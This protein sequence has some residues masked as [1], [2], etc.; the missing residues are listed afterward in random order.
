M[1][2]RR[3]TIKRGDTETWT[4]TTGHAGPDPPFQGATAVV[5]FAKEKGATTNKIDGKPLDSFDTVDPDGAWA[6]TPT[7][8]EVDEVGIY[9]IYLRATYADGSV[10]RFPTKGFW[11]RTI[12]RTHEP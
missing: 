12:Q 3:D 7:A 4:G 11:E 9:E 5:I 2:D 1:T 6:Y 10:K 8:A